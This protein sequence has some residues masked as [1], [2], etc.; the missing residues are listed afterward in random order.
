MV[1]K[2]N[3]GGGCKNTCIYQFI[4]L[5]APPRYNCFPVDPLR[6]NFATQGTVS[7][8]GAIFPRLVIHFCLIPNLE[9][10]LDPFLE[11]FLELFLEFEHDASLH[12][13]F[14]HFL[15][16]YPKKFT[17]LL[18]PAQKIKYHYVTHFIQVVI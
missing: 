18:K 7:N 16:F 6:R 1:V 8:P 10:I 9:L 14:H 4:K 17:L 15:F 13:R 12:F 11:L 2:K 5:A 3:G